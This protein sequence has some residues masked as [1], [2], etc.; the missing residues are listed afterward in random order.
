MRS[1]ARALR[2]TAFVYA[3][4]ATQTARQPLPAIRKH[5]LQ[6]AATRKVC[7][8]RHGRVSAEHVQRA[9]SDRPRTFAQVLVRRLEDHLLEALHSGCRQ[10]H[11]LLLGELDERLQAQLRAVFRQEAGGG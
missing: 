4:P 5:G 2:M 7:V 10:L 11:T 6:S 3:K 8:D 9:S 1:S